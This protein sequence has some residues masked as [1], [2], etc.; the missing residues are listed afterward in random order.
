MHINCPYCVGKQ[1]YLIA[2][3]NIKVPCEYCVK[4]HIA[5]TPKER[6]KRSERGLLRRIADFFTTEITEH[7]PIDER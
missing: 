4:G 6:D 2:N 5:A 1:M 3:T 7:P